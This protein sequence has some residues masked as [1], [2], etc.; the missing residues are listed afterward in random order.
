MR[1]DDSN[2]NA[3]NRGFWLAPEW[4]GWGLMTEAVIAANDFWFDVLGFPVLRTGKAVANAGSRRISEKEPG[5]V[6][7]T[8]ARAGM[9]RGG[10]L[11]RL[12][13]LL[14]MSGGF[15]GLHIRV[16]II[17]GRLYSARRVSAGLVPAAR[18]AGISAARSA[19]TA[20]E[21]R[22]TPI[23]SGSSGLVW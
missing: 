9:F 1:G 21:P 5:C 6:S 10:F 16:E 14:R 8:A 13:R 2:P 7:W 18:A 22:V 15:G 17:Q 20:R 23:E 4:Q 3:F 11:Q 12:G 19:M